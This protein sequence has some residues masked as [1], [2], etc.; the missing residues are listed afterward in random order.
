MYTDLLKC[1]DKAKH[2]AA[3]LALEGTPFA[4]LC[5]GVDVLKK[6][7]YFLYHLHSIDSGVDFSVRSRK[8]ASLSLISR[9]PLNQLQH[10]S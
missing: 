9:L 8:A 5:I 7:A 10:T 4:A 1:K 2:L 6:E 3:A